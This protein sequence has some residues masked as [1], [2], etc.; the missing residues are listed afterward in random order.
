MYLKHRRQ[1]AFDMPVWALD[2]EGFKTP[3]WMM[4]VSSFLDSS[5]AL[6]RA[7][8]QN[9]KKVE[10]GGGEGAPSPVHFFSL[11]FSLWANVIGRSEVLT[12]PD[13]SS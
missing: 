13:R 6:G 2:P 11:N 5:S 1:L 10:G 9:W 8:F 12:G 3:T 7:A 4:A